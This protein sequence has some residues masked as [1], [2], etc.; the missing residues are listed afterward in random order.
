VEVDGGFGMDRYPLAPVRNP[1][2]AEQAD[3]PDG[4]LI[5]AKPQAFDN[6]SVANNAIVC[7]IVSNNDSTLNFSF[8]GLFGHFQVFRHKILKSLLPA[9]E[10]RHS[11]GLEFLSG[12]GHGYKTMN[13]LS[14]NLDYSRAHLFLYPLIKKYEQ[15]VTE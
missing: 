8:F 14:K 7:D 3:H 9:R 6:M 11:E 15:Q 13:Y 2:V 12:V 10:F 4:F 1:F 5:A